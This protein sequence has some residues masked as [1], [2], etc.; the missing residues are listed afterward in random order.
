MERRHA[1][2]YLGDPASREAI[3]LRKQ[4]ASGAR[5]ALEEQYLDVLERTLQARPLQAQLGGDPTIANRVRA[6][7]LVRYYRGGEWQDRIEVGSVLVVLKAVADNSG[8]WLRPSPYGPS[9]SISYAR[10]MREKLSTRRLLTGRLLSTVR[11]ALSLTSVSG[12]SLPIIGVLFAHSLPKF[13]F[14]RSFSLPK[15]HRDHIQAIYNAHMLHST[16]VDPFK[17][18]L[19][20]LMGKL[21]PTKRTVPLVTATTEDWLWFQLAMV[22]FF[23][24]ELS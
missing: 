10:D 5:A 22:C 21:D 19:Y 3:E 16:S 17:L 15:P 14:M 6:F 11:I 12:W 9:Y 20:K 4:I 13:N 1:R 18:A 8:S 23:S 24:V 2:A 7:L